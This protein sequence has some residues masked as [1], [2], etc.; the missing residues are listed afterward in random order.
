MELLG[1]GVMAGMIAMMLRRAIIETGIRS[2]DPGRHQLFCRREGTG[3]PLLLLHGLAGSWRYWRRG[4][5]GLRERY[6][7]YIPDLIGFGRSPKPRGDYSIAMHVEALT[8]LLER[9]DV[10]VVLAGHSMGSIVALGL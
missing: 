8:R 3:P 7:V 5:E 1:T 4:L 2:Y 9:I 10:E 6:T